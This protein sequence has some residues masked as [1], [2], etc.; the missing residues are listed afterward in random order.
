MPKRPDRVL[1]P[2]T[3]FTRDDAVP[4]TG[5]V[6]RHPA[7]WK[8]ATLKDLPPARYLLRLHL[9]NATI[10]AVYLQPGA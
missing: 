9:S 5:N 7:S 10:F 3:G 8:S 2:A 6:L 1:F 4:I